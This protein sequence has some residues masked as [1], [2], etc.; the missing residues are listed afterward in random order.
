MAQVSEGF[1]CSTCSVTST[2]RGHLCNPVKLERRTACR[3]KG[4]PKDSPGQLCEN[5]AN[6]IKYACVSCGRMSPVPDFLCYPK[7][8]SKAALRAMKK[9]VRPHSS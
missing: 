4:E 3:Y 8:I 2:E 7:T 1:I 6:K 9:G 5:I